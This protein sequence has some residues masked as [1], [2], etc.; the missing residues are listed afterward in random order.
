[1]LKKLHLFY[2][3]KIV[4]SIGGFFS[5]H[6]DAYAYLN[7]T[8]ESFPYGPEFCKL[9][10]EVGFQNVQAHPLMGGIATIYTGDRL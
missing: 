10:E 6:K 7:Q 4:P 3:R 9:F 2:L 5:G 1:M 8:I